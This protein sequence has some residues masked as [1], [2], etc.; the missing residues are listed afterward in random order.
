MSELQSK[1]SV[2]NVRAAGDRKEPGADL[3]GLVDA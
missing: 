3:S 1:N 2:K